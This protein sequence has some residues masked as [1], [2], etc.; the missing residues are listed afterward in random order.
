M[1]CGT[2]SLGRRVLAFDAFA[3]ACYTGGIVKTMIVISQNTRTDPSYAIAGY[4]ALI[5]LLYLV[6]MGSPPQRRAC[7]D[8]LL[9]NNIVQVC[10]AKIDHRF[11]IH[12]QLGITT[13]WTLAMEVPLGS[14]LSPSQMNE[15]TA[16]M[17]HYAL[18]VPRI[19]VEQ[20]IS[21]D[22]AWQSQIIMDGANVSPLHFK[23]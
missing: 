13:L 6:K 18:V 2:D 22:T 16:A 1:S 15:I 17:C 12:R 11:I 19:F 5:A 21:P 3:M 23:S 7:L 9:E 10:L 14:K 4:D 8:Q 20:V